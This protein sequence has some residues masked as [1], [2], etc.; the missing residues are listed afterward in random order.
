MFKRLYP[1]LR[2]WLSQYLRG[3]IWV[4]GLHVLKTWQPVN[5]DIFLLGYISSPKCINLT[6]KTLEA[7]VEMIT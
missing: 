6:L 3:D 2:H 5:L 4:G 7:L 1:L